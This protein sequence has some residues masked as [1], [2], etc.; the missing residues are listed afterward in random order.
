MGNQWQE[1]GHLR[2]SCTYLKDHVSVIWRKTAMQ[3]MKEEKVDM[4]TQDNFLKE[5]YT[6]I[7]AGITA[8]SSYTF[9]LHAVKNSSMGLRNEEQ[10]E[11][12]SISILLW[13]A[14]HTLMRF[15]WWKRALCPQPLPSNSSS[16]YSSCTL[17]WTRPNLCPSIVTNVTL[18]F[19]PTLYLPASW[20]FM[21]CH[22]RKL[23]DVMFHIFIWTD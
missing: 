18:C 4:W 12:S 2:F 7:A 8:Q 5:N 10:D 21:R 22:F 13:A 20:W 9:H 11:R 1:I 3:S 23:V 14:N 6:N 15:E 16:S 19:S 17:C